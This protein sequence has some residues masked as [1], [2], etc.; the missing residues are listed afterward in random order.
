MSGDMNK[1]DADQFRK[2]GRGYRRGLAS[3]LGMAAI[4]SSIAVA[5]LVPS[6]DPPPPPTALGAL[7][8]MAASHRA[9]GIIQALQIDDLRIVSAHDALVEKAD[10]LALSQHVALNGYEITALYAGGW[11]DAITYRYDPETVMQMLLEMKDL[12]AVIHAEQ[13]RLIESVSM[14]GDVMQSGVWGVDHAVRT[15]ILAAIEPA[16]AGRIVADYA[17]EISTAPPDLAP[18]LLRGML[19]VSFALDRV[20]LYDLNDRIQAE[21]QVIADAEDLAGSLPDATD[22]WEDPSL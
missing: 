20:F 11:E 1:P 4:S 2:K 16:R 10:A 17:L 21:H 22:E 19:S 7:A 18:D 5:S 15:G 3:I 8:V 14:T 12:D 13:V 6:S 9:D